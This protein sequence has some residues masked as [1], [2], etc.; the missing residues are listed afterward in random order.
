VGS[1]CRVL[2]GRGHEKGRQMPPW[3]IWDQAAL[4]GG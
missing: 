4:G 1:I 2:A 3:F